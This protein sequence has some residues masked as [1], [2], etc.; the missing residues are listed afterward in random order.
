MNLR[1][2]THDPDLRSWVQSANDAGTDFPIQNLPFGIFRHRGSDEA[3]RG[4]VAIGEQIVD[5]AAVTE[6][7]VFGGDVAIAA[8][9]AAG[10]T[11]NALMQLGP[12]AWSRLRA[13]LSATLAYGSEDGAA[14]RGCLV[15]QAEAEYALPA[16]IGDFTDFCSSIHHASAVARLRRP[17]A[18]LP[19][20]YLWVPIGY[21]GRSSSIGI[22]GQRFHRPCGQVLPKGAEQP[23]F[24]PSWQLDYELEL[25]AY[26]G[27]GNA[28]GEPVPIGVAEAHVFGLCLLNDWS[29]RDIQA[30]ESRP[31]GPLLGKNFATTVSPWVVTLEA[32]A[33]FRVPGARPAGDP[34]PLPYLDSRANAAAGGFDIELEVLLQTATMRARTLPPQRLARSNFRHA[35]WTLAQLLAHHS[36]N[37]CNLRPGDLIG[38]GTL[39]GPSPEECGS[40]LELTHGGHRPITLADGE[41]RSFIEDGDVVVMRGCCEREGAARIGF[42]QLSAEVLPALAGAT[43]YP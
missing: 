3:W 25:G 6:A 32:L 13:A 9:T 34:R 36:V 22:C 21:H 8:S 39:S 17:D 19:S 20:N 16:H 31:L 24:G 4:G 27:V 30:W 11:L 38:T 35:Y 37:G 5:L 10:P 23:V 41:T 43:T 42:G 1:N 15:P 40:L 28:P 2:G 7:S 18:P 14:L 33:P 29:A 12:A 26:V